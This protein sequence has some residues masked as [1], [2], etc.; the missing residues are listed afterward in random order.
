MVILDLIT[1]EI[2]IF[3]ILDGKLDV[4]MVRALLLGNIAEFKVKSKTRED[5]IVSNSR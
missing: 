5:L 1:K 4:E 3:R 2:A